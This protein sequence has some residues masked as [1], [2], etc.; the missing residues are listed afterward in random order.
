MS[1]HFYSPG[2]VRRSHARDACIGP[3]L[4]LLLLPPL[5]VVLLCI[6]NLMIKI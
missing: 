3:P 1:I 6:G 2:V 5:L 4:M